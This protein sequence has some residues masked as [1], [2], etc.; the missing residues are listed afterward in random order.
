MVTIAGKGDE[1]N[2]IHFKHES[3]STTLPFSMDHWVPPL[4]F[5]DKMSNISFPAFWE[6]KTPL[7]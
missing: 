6:W 2:Y 7:S 5:E 3:G 1:S 4:Y